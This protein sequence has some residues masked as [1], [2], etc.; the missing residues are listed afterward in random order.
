MGS[1]VVGLIKYARSEGLGVQLMVSG[2]GRK[3]MAAAGVLVAIAGGAVIA[4]ADDPSA[5][6]AQAEGGLSASPVL[7]ERATQVGA[8]NTM[9]I[10]NRS[11]GALDVTVNARPWTQSSSGLV[12]PKRSATLAGVEVSEKAFTLAAGKSKDVTVT[13]KSAP[14]GGSLYGAVEIVGLPTDIAKR[15]GVV[16]G[17]R[18]LGSLRFNSP[19]PVYSLKLGATKVAGTGSKKTLTLAVRNAG[20]TITPVTGS[21]RL[22]GPTGTKNLSVKATRILPGKSIALGLASGNSLGAGSYTATV[23]LTQAKQKTTITKKITVRR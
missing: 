4:R 19:T 13:Q 21:V 14:A 16:A 3:T 7:I 11:N 1:R 23:T 15:K 8:A 10:A 17:Y 20:N 6:A 18:I 22:K 2:T 5:R 9:T 12:S